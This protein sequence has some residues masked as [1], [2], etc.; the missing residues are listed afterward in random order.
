[1]LPP[2]SYLCIMDLVA[3]SKISYAEYLSHEPGCDISMMQAYIHAFQSST[4]KVLDHDL[5]KKINKVSLS[6]LSNIPAGQYRD[7]VG[8]YPI[9]I[10]QNKNGRNDQYSG[11]QAGLLEFVNAWLMED[12]AIHSIDF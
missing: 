4:Q 1:M 7:K 10:Y 3:I 5:I 2:F 12:N 9:Y 8:S 11:T 6:H